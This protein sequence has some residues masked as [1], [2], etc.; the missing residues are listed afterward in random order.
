MEF[1]LF[2]YSQIVYFLTATLGGGGDGEGCTKTF[3][4]T[5]DERT[6]SQNGMPKSI[7]ENG[8]WEL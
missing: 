6:I 4:L 1:M 5:P 7:S 3:E 2:W 8:V